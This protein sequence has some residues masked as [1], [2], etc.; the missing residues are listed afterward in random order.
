MLKMEL[1]NRG[2]SDY[3]IDEVL[4]NFEYDEVTIIERLV[5]QKFGKYNL[6]DPKVEIKVISFLMHRGFS[7]DVI[8]QGISNISKD[9]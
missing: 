3:I 1:S 8:K 7:F 9:E 2:I 5:R 4:N 6:T